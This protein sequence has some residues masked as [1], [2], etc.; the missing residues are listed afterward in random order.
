MSSDT[1]SK[2]AFERLCEKANKGDYAAQCALAAMFEEGKDVPC[3]YEAAIFWYSSASKSKEFKEYAEKSLKRVQ[4][5]KQKED[6]LLEKTDQASKKKTN[7]TPEQSVHQNG[8][9]NSNDSSD[10]KKFIYFDLAITPKIIFFVFWVSVIISI[11]WAAIQITCIFNA[12]FSQ[13]NMKDAWLYLLI[14]VLTVIGILLIPLAIRIICEFIIAI[15]K[16][17]E[18]LHDIR[19][20]IKRKDSL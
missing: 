8:E 7:G 11:L 17:Q 2:I 16:I 1:E 19:N 9:F 6:E 10:I 13:G 18:Y 20:T 12:Y 14:Q 3:D 4:E 5:K 15:F